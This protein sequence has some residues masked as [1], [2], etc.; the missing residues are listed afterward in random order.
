M[1]ADVDTV[2]IPDPD[3]REPSGKAA[4]FSAP[5]VPGILLQTKLAIPPTRSNLVPRP[6]LARELDGAGSTKLTI[7]SAPAGFGKTTILSAW[8]QQSGKATAWLSLGADD[9]EPAQFLQYVISALGGIAPGVGAG[10][11]AMLQALPPSPIHSALLTL[12]NELSAIPEQF[13]LILDDY[14]LIEDQEIHTALTF[15][16]DHMPGRMHIILSGRSDPPLP[17]SRLRVRGH[18]VELRQKDLRFTPE[19]ASAFLSESA[20]VQL[21]PQQIMKLEART[22]GWIAGLQ[23]AALSMRD[24][25]DIPTFIEQFSGSHRFVID[26]LADEVLSQQSDALRQF[27]KETSILDRLTASLCDAV[28][29][30]DDSAVLLGELE[31]T[32]AFLIPLDDHRRWYRY[33]QLFRDFLRFQL[34]RDEAV[35]LHRRAS[36]WLLAHGL[37]AEAVRLALESGEQEQAARAITSAAPSAFDQGLLNLLSGWLNA[38]PEKVVLE[39]AELAIYKGFVLIFASTMDEVRPYLEAAEGALSPESPDSIRGRL[40]S[41]QAHMALIE[42]RID[43]CVRMSKDALEHLQEEDAAFRN[44][45]FNLLGQVLEIK[46]DVAAAADIYGQ[47]FR[48]GWQR[49]D[50]VGA[51]VVL[52]NLVFSLNELGKRR[53]AVAWCRQLLQEPAVSSSQGSTVADVVSLSQSLLSYEA[54]ELEVAQ[55]QAERALERLTGINISQGVLWAQYILARIHLVKGELDAVRSLTQ[56]GRQLAAQ[57]GRDAVHGAWFAALEAQIDLQQGELA[58]SV[59]W[60]EEAGYS[61]DTTP[62]HWVEQAYFTFVHLLLAQERLTEAQALLDRM[63]TSAAEGGRARKL[64]T[65]YLLQAR[66]HLSRNGLMAGQERVKRALELAAAEGYRRAFLDEGPELLPLLSRERETAPAFVDELL[67][68][69]ARGELVSGSVSKTAPALIETLTERELDVLRLVVNGMSNREVA[70]TLVVT[71]GTVKKHLNNIFGKLAVKSR[72]QAA[73]KARELNLLE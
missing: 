44:L 58:K 62:H 10:S 63:E 23:L 36:E 53:E 38:L 66:A 72:T 37:H 59:R 33:H 18:L 54:N 32:N 9:D 6:R 55:E 13:F 12:I 41:L 70:S 52:T 39:S 47:A 34:G 31:K 73:V 57:I 65:V 68:A 64:I 51:L 46:G 15:L 28:T 56:K 61:P 14:H 4:G 5:S 45:T 8:A 24:R 69:F 17:L 1:I 43:D 3:N 11:M 21:S 30:R 20:G 27:L 2:P 60:A 22:E 7:I 49:G 50:Q 19:E 16:L 29:G 26:Y 25:E 40:L 35:A 42:G 71:L 67:A 48:S